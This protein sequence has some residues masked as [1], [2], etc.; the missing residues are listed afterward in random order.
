M[1]HFESDRSINNKTEI[2]PAKSNGSST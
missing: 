2:L 1:Q